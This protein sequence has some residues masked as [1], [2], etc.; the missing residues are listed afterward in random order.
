MIALFCHFTVITLSLLNCVP[1]ILHM[2]LNSDTELAFHALADRN[3]WIL[4]FA[5]L[6]I[7]MSVST[8]M[9]LDYIL[10]SNKENRTKMSDGVPIPRMAV[11]LG[12]IIPDFLIF[13]FV[14]L[15]GH[16]EVLPVIVNIRDSLFVYGWLLYLNKLDPSRWTLTAIRCVAF[17]NVIAD[18]LGTFGVH[19]EPKEFDPSVYIITFTCIALICLIFLFFRW[20]RY[21]CNETSKN[22]MIM[23]NNYITNCYASSLLFFALADWLIFFVPPCYVPLS[24]SEFGIGYLTMYTLVLAFS[25]LVVSVLMARLAREDGLAAKHRLVAKVYH[26][27]ES[28]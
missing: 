4:Y 25:T 1:F 11:V 21:Y 2:S 7:S 22:D 15:L 28:F 19:Y 13:I 23:K 14:V 3:V 16:Y 8:P 10:D 24:F 20:F 5:S 26:I 17:S 12:V 18:I 9:L 27:Y 6:I